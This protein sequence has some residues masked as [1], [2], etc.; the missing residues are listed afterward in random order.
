MDISIKSILLFVV[1]A[2]AAYMVDTKVP[3]GPGLKTV[4]R[5]VCIIVAILVLLH[6]FGVGPGVRVH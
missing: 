4:W 6:L 2:V 5:V 3:M 1:L